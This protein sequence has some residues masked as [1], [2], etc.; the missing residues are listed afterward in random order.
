MSSRDGTLNGWPECEECNKG[1]CVCELFLCAR[2]FQLV[3]I[4]SG[5][6]TQRA[7][8]PAR[9]GSRLG[10]RIPQPFID[11]CVPLF[12]WEIFFGNIF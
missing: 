4:A 6:E 8:R 12:L 3:S 9:N 11:V 1:L 2:P 10:R 7:R 5:W